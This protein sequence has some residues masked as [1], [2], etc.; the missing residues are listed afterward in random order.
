M[1]IKDRHYIPYIIG[2]FLGIFIML[3]LA[4]CYVGN[5]NR[6]ENLVDL[7]DMPSEKQQIENLE[8]LCKVWGYTKYH[9]PAFLSGEKEWDTELLSLIP[10]VQTAESCDDVNTV[11]NDWFISLGEA[12]WGGR[13]SSVVAWFS[14]KGEDQVFQANTDWS[15]DRVYLGQELVTSLSQINT[16]PN[17]NRNEAPVYFNGTVPVFSNEKNYENFDY[18]DSCFRLLGLFRFWNAIE[19]YYPYLDI[20][21]EAWDEIL[22][23]YISQMLEVND[24]HGYDLLI[25]SL[26][27]HLH[28]CHVIYDNY[29]YLQKEI[30][31]NYAPVTLIQTRDG[32]AV[33]DVHEAC[34][35]QVGDIPV[36]VDAVPIEDRIAQVKQYQVVPTSDKLERTVTPY[37]LSSQHSTIDI[38]VLRDGEIRSLSVPA[39]QSV[40][41]PRYDTQISHALLENNI[42][43]INPNAL[44]EGEIHMIMEEFKDTDGLIVDMRQYPSM[45]FSYDFACYLMTGNQQFMELTVPSQ[46]VPGAFLRTANESCYTGYY[47]QPHLKGY[48]IYQYDK[49]IVI[50]MNQHT[51]SRGE[52][53]VLAFTNAENVVTVGESTNGS[54]GDM[55]TLPLPD[56]NQVS[57]SSLGIYTVDGGQTQRIGLMPD[58]YVEETI[59]GLREGRDELIEAAIHYLNNGD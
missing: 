23:Y 24:K 49:T 48:N 8:K 12:E 47:N 46:A 29:R 50:L 1:T 3:P 53:A 30:G 9:H 32:L 31:W 7:Y 44:D 15:T 14:A 20:L 36:A 21:D 55:T 28:D 10:Q 37:L 34:S 57:F 18:T 45:N 54:N 13:P 51:I 27:T 17:V 42:G 38:D 59:A 26:S 5:S 58:I 6:L 43:L 35:L 19:Y 33:S 2:V 39:Y 25:A 16:I 56:G 4:S 52:T 22:P 40:H 11:L 41:I